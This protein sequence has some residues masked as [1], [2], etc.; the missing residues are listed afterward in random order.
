MNAN[1]GI[2]ASDHAYDYKGVVLIHS[3]CNLQPYF[4][5]NRLNPIYISGTANYGRHCYTRS[6]C[7]SSLFHGADSQQKLL[8]KVTPDITTFSACALRSNVVTFRRSIYIV[9]P[10]PAFSVYFRLVVVLLL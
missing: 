5:S 3:S 2:P 1:V 4:Y 6:M 9:D 8:S 7:M 10:F